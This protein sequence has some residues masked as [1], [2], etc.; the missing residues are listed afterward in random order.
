LT[1][2]TSSSPTPSPAAARI[3][4]PVLARTILLC[5]TIFV[6][7]A[8]TGFGLAI[9]LRPPAPPLPT[10]G[11]ERPPDPPIDMLVS[12][13]QHELDLS[14][15]VTKQVKD[16]YT[17]R[18]AAIKKIRDTMSPEY[19]GLRADIQK[20]LTPEQFASWDKHFQQIATHMFPP[21]PRHGPPPEG[22]YGPGDGGRP[23][24]PPPDGGFPGGPDGPGGPGGPGGGFPP[25]PH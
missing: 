12:H 4:P 16:I 1:T 21:P 18:Y 6:G 7:G 8:G 2:E 24:P 17:K 10:N 20:V 13:M 22:G 14:P 9:A 23:P 15:E 5:A 11:V 19:D 25:P 3:G